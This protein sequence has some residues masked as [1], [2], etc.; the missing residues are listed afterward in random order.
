MSAADEPP[1]GGRP[2]TCDLLIVNGCVLTM[3]SARTI[4]ADGAIAVR[5]RHIVAIGPSR[6][7][8][9]GWAAT[10]R[11]DAGGGTVHPGFIDGHY[12]AG[13]HLSRGSITD[14]P[15]PPKEAG[16]GTGVF[17][18]WIN[19]ITEED[20]YAS[21]LLASAELA[22]NG[23]TGFVDAS[24]SFFPDAIAD[25]VEAVGIR[26][27]LTDCMLWDNVG[28]EPMPNEIPRAPCDQARALREMGGQ[29]KRNRDANGLV[30]GHVALYGSGSAS[31]ELL[32][33]AMALATREGAMYHQ[34][35]SLSK[36]EAE[37]DRARF[38]KP[39]L[40]HFAEKGLI[41]PNSVFTHMNILEDAEVDAIAD[42]GMALVWHPGN[43]MYYAISQTGRSAFPSLH[44]RGTSIAFG[45]DIAKAW[46][47]G[48]LGFIAYLVT[49]EW[50]GYLTSEAILEMFTLGGAR[51]IGLPDQLGSIEVGKRADIVI[52]SNDHPDAQ[53][54][55]DV[56]R[57]LALVSRTKGVDT[58]IC[59]GETI[60]RHGRLVRIDE[61]EIYKLA[62]KSAEATALRAGLKPTGNWPR[63]T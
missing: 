21:A 39:A 55:V 12:H 6:D 51:A 28:V 60:V 10:R 2:Q 5:G 42:S 53:P 57:Q 31:E 46:A 13:L 29:L 40:V 23:F 9:K 44:K 35:Q 38:G 3:D 54:N 1:P 30:R 32:R 27:S 58:V 24:T 8:E 20:E 50:G 37:F 26:T 18:R 62:R 19:A 45:T 11:I 49:R 15:N 16:G 7:I 33:E 25:A 14:D 4:Y 22:R 56:V 52:R 17:T 34:H 47:F 41:G 36:D 61:N 48:D 43:F 63:V 59:N